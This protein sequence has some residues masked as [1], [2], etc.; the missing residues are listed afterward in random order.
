M[1]TRSPEHEIEK[2]RCLL[3]SW[4][5]IQLHCKIFP[6][7]GRSYGIKRHETINSGTFGRY[8]CQELVP[9]VLGQAVDLLFIF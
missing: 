6:T 3:Q 7:T 1:N 9:L 4:Q 2:K 8:W 5:V